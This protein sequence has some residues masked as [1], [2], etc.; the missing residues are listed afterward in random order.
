MKDKFHR[1]AET[2]LSIT[3]LPVMDSAAVDVR[4]DPC[5]PSVHFGRH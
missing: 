4:A 1:I 2:K 5:K 3:S